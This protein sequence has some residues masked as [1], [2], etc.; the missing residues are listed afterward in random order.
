MT[1]L[2]TF[3]LLVLV[4][5]LAGIIWVLDRH[6]LAVEEP[7]REESK[8]FPPYANDVE[9]IV[10]T[11]G[12][13]EMV[14]TRP[15]GIWVLERPIQA[16]VN[17]EK[18]ERIL[19]VMESLPVRER[20]TAEQR[21]LRDLELADYGL[22]DT[23]IRLTI[24]AGQR[25]DDIRVGNV[26]AL[27]DMVYVRVGDSMDVIATSREMVLALPSGVDEMR[28]RALLRGDAY[29]TVRLEITRPDGFIQ[30]ARAAGGWIIQQPVSFRAD[31]AQVNRMLD[32][33]FSTPVS[34]F[35]WDPAAGPAVD[36][37][38]AR[39]RVEA[40]GL[41]PDDAALRIRVWVA[42]DEVGQEVVFGKPLT[43]GRNLVYAKLRDSE[44][45]V[46]VGAQVQAAFRVGVGDLRDRRI[47]ALSAA[48]SR[49]FVCRQGDRRVVLRRQNGAG[50]MIVE[51]I[52]WR[53]D[54]PTVS[55]IVD[56]VA[57]MAALSFE[58]GVPRGLKELGMDP[59]W[60][61][62]HLGTVAPPDVVQV[63][64]SAREPEGDGR[65]RNKDLDR[66][67]L[68]NVI[69]TNGTVLARYDGTETYFWVS[70]ESIS[71]LAPTPAEPLVYR[72]RLMMAIPPESVSSLSLRREK[73]EQRVALL[74]TGNVWVA[75]SPA[76]GIPDQ[77]AIRDI[78]CLLANLRAL[79]IEYHG[80]ENLE[81]YGLDKDAT[82]LVVSLSGGEGIQ[83]S[84]YMGFRSRTDGV[85]AMVQGQDLV[86]VLDKGQVERLNADL[87]RPPRPANEPR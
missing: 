64:P 17:P 37:G 13:T 66:I 49:Y 86:F 70:A 5:L 80:A 72:D 28:D 56:S 33:L 76:T 73:G 16:Q 18:I 71:R 25:R 63:P 81:A 60:C 42:G 34:E 1:S 65:K 11:R 3:R 15:K 39:E 7:R 2:T 57:G 48:D 23:A 45:V 50:W 67:W 82:V 38:R 41:S 55:A 36:K 26:S 78:L 31:A 47:F 12:Q 9:S 74:S 21:R 30:L 10:L 87:V 68:S 62:V 77:A 53:A 85:Y 14:L 4:A 52:Q 22:A 24:S 51:P 29:R 46:A 40:F 83:K 59:P 35:V 27:S 44:S 6:W 61:M 43:D 84:L 32:V 69:Q 20:I 58:D 54:E 79:R 8:L 19:S 75:E